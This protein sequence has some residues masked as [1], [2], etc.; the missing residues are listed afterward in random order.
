M[1]ARIP[2]VFCL[3][4]LLLSCNEEKQTE[5]VQEDQVPA[6]RVTKSDRASSMKEQ[7]RVQD[8]RRTALE[9][10]TNLPEGEERNQAI[11]QWVWDTFEMDPQVAQEGIAK[12]TPGS[13]EKNRL[14]EH[15][16]MRMVERD[17]DEAKTWASS[18]E[19]DEEKSVAFGAIAAAVSKESP[20]DAAQLL[21]DSGVAGRDFDVAVVQVIQNWSATAPDKAAD[22]VARFDNGESRKAGLKA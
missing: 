6:K 11:A 22:W 13:P 5:Q 3:S 1:I 10:A 19:T 16:A 2:A 21:S 17:I 12:L 14:L 7:K 20:E 9:A 8:Q 15:F 18:L 4:A